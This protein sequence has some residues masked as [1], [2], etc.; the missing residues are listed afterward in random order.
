M[1]ELRYIPFPQ[2]HHAAPVKAVRGA[3]LG[4]GEPIEVSLYLK[5]RPTEA[6]ARQPVVDRQAILAARAIRHAPDIETIRRFAADHGLSVVEADGRR[7]RV[8]LVGSVAAMRRAF[9]VDL[10]HYEGAGVVFRAYEGT[11]HLREDI[12]P[13]T[14]SV[15]GLDTRPVAAPRLLQL[16]G[17]D[18]SAVH[19]PN[20]IGALYG[21]PTTPTGE[22]ECI[23]LIELAGGYRQSDI[24][25]AFAAMGLVPPTVVAIG[26]DGASNAPRP[27]SSADVEVGLDIQVAGAIAPGARI[28]VYFTSNT[29]A[30]FADAISQAAT[31]TTNA[32]SVMSISWGA[33]E[34][35]YSE[36]A[37][38]TLD[39]ALQ[40]AATAGVTVTVAAG[41]NLATDGIEDGRVHVDFPASSPFV[42]GC[43]GTAITVANRVITREIVWNNG[44][45]GTGGGISTV[46]PVPAFQAQVKLPTNVSTGGAGRG[47]PDVA[48][49]AAPA[50]GYQVTIDGE[51]LAVGGT[52]AVAPLWAGFFVL[53]NQARGTP[54]GLANPVLYATNPQGF[55]EIVVGNNR[56]AD[57]PLGYD[58]GPGWNACTGLGVMIGAALFRQL[59]DNG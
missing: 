44:T 39:T 16:V 54:L 38:T 46:F 31:D 48:A 42:V 53:V 10:Y 11:L 20:A 2:S 29:D 35:Q 18:R 59:A 3:R 7:R 58:A 37:R 17:A 30:G 15:L 49:D 32:P 26:V 19:R 52:S 34:S 28:A 33:P 45:N 50:S 25:A 22:G 36:Q 55:R 41:D 13:I 47:V 23:A 21:I 51:N 8:R 14:E 6:D 4:D 57:S 40:D 27:A 24:T 9:G 5:P 56:P 1:V 43:G 12:A